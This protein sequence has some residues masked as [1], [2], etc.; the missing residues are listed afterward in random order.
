MAVATASNQ[1][2]IS[3]EDFVEVL[4]GAVPT[5]HALTQEYEP[6]LLTA[7][8]NDFPSGMTGEAW[9]IFEDLVAYG[10]EFMFGRRV[11]RLGGR[12]RGRPVSDMQAQTPQGDIVVVDTKASALGFDL[13]WP[14]LRPLVEYVKRQRERQ[15][16]HLQLIGALVVSSAFQ[17]TED[18]MQELSRDFFGETRVPV[19]FIVAD[20]LANSV[21]LFRTRPDVRNGIRWNRILTGG[22]IDFRSIE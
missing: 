17:Q 14:E 3:W 18:R 16:G 12:K 8:Q 21:R 4:G 1:H 13:G 9:L 19:S 6:A 20:V 10:L 11:R 22:H 2:S 7:A 5:W 15:R